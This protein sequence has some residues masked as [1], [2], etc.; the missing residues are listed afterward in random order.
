MCLPHI[1]IFEFQKQI[2]PPYRLGFLGEVTS[3]ALIFA[4]LNLKKKTCTPAPYGRT[5]NF[6][7]KTGDPPTPHIR[8]FDFKKRIQKKR[9]VGQYSD[10]K[11]PS[12]SLFIFKKKR[13]LLWS[14]F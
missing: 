10:K 7:K 9:C 12:K 2:P 8:T 4:L 13:S 5:F 6:D 3:F 1:R 14:R 11:M